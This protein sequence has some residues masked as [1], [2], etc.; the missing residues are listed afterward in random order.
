MV[1]GC[2]KQCGGFVEVQSQRGAGTCFTLWFPRSK[3]EVTPS[4]R[5]PPQAARGNASVLLVEDNL[6]VAKLT[7]RMLE[8]AGYRVRAANG[9]EEALRL[10][11]IAPDD[12]LVTDVE[13]P[14]M[15][16]V[17][18]SEQIRALTPLLR[19]LYITGHSNQHIDLHAHAGRCA[20]VTKPFRHNDLLLALESL[21][22]R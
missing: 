1:F 8:T 3:L 16:G 7:R 19:T 15:S 10:W 5:P 11:R 14:G 6:Q 2:M 17:R 18:L 4:K 9:P 22:T 21:L 12:V 20:L 13:M